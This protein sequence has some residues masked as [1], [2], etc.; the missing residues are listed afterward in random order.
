M[1][2][3]SNGSGRAARVAL[4]ARELRLPADPPPAWF[5]ALYAGAG[6]RPRITVQYVLRVL[7]GEQIIGAGLPLHGLGVRRDPIDLIPP[8][9]RFV[10]EDWLTSALRCH[11]GSLPGLSRIAERASRRWDPEGNPASVL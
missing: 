11:F 1:K 10:L 2:H 3:E 8:S 7:A 5:M 4:Y 6:Q 9:R